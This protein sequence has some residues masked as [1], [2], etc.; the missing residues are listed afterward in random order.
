M[1]INLRIF[2]NL[3][4]SIN[5]RMFINL[6]VSI[7]LRMFIN[8]TVS[9]NLTAGEEMAS[10]SAVDIIYDENTENYLQEERLLE[11]S[12][13]KSGTKRGHYI[14]N[15]PTCEAKKR[16]LA[17]AEN[18]DNWKAVALANGIATSTAYGWI[19][20]SQDP[21]KKCGGSRHRKVY[22]EHIEKMIGYVEE[23]PYIT[24]KEIRAMFSLETGIT[25]VSTN[26]IHNYLE[27]Q[28]YC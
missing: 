9:I 7:N 18:H 4:V 3:T 23:D 10:S 27:G 16:V 19:R 28:M 21:L 13:V 24:L 1:F 2:I 20:R 12:G 6:T 8:L 14:K 22:P 11:K 5:L 26:T 17:A 25:V 15:T